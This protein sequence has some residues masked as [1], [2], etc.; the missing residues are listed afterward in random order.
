[1]DI[2]PCADRQPA[3]GDT[4]HAA[5]RGKDGARARGKP[6]HRGRRQALA[7][8]L[9]VLALIASLQ[10]GTGATGARAAVAAYARPSSPASEIDGIAEA[11]ESGAAYGPLPD[12][13]LQICRPQGAHGLRP[14]VVLIHGGSWLQG[15]L[16][17]YT[18]LCA[19]LAARGFVAV[20]INYRLADSARPDTQWPAQLVDAQL[21]VR[22]LRSRAPALRVDP[23]RICA[24]G[25][26]AGAHLAVFLGALHGIHAGDQ[27]S[28]LSTYSSAVSCVVDDYGPVDLISLNEALTALL[29]SSPWASPARYRDA[30]PIFAVNTRTAPTLIVHG[31]QD[32]IIPISQSLEL[33]RALESRHVPVRMITYTGGH[34]LDSI[35]DQ[36]AQALNAQQIAFLVAQLHP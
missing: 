34:G 29:G 28:R 30:S 33:L 12:E 1:M 6:V 3:T 36:Q 23:A 19:I 2:P 9:F 17:D 7:G 35:P 5:A 31:T 14:A 18:P 21:A 26:S 13:R 32:S 25:Q 24:L 4:T 16:T 15:D 27:A 11:A 20:T 22:W 10:G 8:L